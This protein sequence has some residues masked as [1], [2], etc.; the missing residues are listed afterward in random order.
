MAI[1]FASIDDVPALVALGKRMHAITRFRSFTY[2]D[3]RVGKA[4]RAALD[5]GKGRYVCFIAEDAEKQV[6]GA[7]LAGATACG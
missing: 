6:V 7:L 3:E 5:Q 2:D 1:R 4:L